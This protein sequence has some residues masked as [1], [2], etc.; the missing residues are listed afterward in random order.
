MNKRT[1]GTFNA[2]ISLLWLTTLFRNT[3]RCVP[4]PAAKVIEQVALNVISFKDVAKHQFMSCIKKYG[5]KP[6]KEAQNGRFQKISIPIS[7]MTFRISKGEGGSR[8][9]N[10]GGMEGIYDWKSE[11]MGEFHRWD[12]WSRKCRVSSLKTLL[13]WTF[14]VRK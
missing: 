11:G 5:L 3:Q 2:I 7:R 14:V 6:A 4:I 12:F 8:L 13:L 10:S 1:S 9:W